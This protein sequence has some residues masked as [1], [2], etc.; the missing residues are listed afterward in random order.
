MKKKNKFINLKSIENGIVSIDD[1]Y[2]KIFEIDPINFN[3][4]SSREQYDVLYQY[5]VF[6]KSCNFDMQIVVQSRKSNIFPHLNNINDFYYKEKSQKVKEMMNDYI[7]LVKD[8]SSKKKSISRRF[9]LITK[10]IAP[11]DVKLDEIKL[12]EVREDFT[13]K[14]LK[15]KQ[16]LTKC[17]NLV[18]ELDENEIINLLYTYLNKKTS[19]L[20]DMNGQPIDYLKEI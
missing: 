18:R 5:K 1:S 20:Q 2:I 10:Y 9:F 11:A 7:N 16:G 6:L 19:V 15:V 4:K 13:S 17:G 3:L 14:F 8:M 12:E